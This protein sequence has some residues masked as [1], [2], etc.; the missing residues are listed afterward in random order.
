[1]AWLSRIGR[2]LEFAAIRIAKG[3]VLDDQMLIE[4][5]ARNLPAIHGPNE[6]AKIKSAERTATRR[7]KQPR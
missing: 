6:S 5:A 3:Q 7:G 1:M 4:I 2:L